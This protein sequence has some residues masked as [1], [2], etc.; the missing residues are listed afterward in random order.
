MKMSKMGITNII[1]TEIITIKTMISHQ[2]PITFTDVVTTGF[3]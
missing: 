1:T 3:V 2:D